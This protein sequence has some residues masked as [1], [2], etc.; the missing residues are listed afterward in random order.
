MKVLRF[1]V[2]VALFL[3]VQVVCDMMLCHL[4][5]WFPVIERNVVLSK[6]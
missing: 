1:E 6:G 5:V 2:L 4:G 3:G